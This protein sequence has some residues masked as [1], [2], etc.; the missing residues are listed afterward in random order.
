M[1]SNNVAG[2]AQYIVW[3]ERDVTSVFFASQYLLLQL[4]EGKLQNPDQ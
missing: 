3:S 2:C 1:K 4:N